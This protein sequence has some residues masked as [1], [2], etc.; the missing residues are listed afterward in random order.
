MNYTPEMLQVM[1]TQTEHVIEESRQAQVAATQAALV[2]LCLDA[3]VQFP[4]TRWLH[5]EDSDQGNYKYL[6]NLLDIHMKPVDPNANFC[7]EYFEDDGLTSYLDDGWG[8]PVW[9]P[10]VDHDGYLDVDAVLV[11][12]QDM[13]LAPPETV[14]IVDGKVVFTPTPHQR[15]STDQ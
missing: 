2:T 3:K 8:S 14:Q 11:K 5:V 10:F 6:L 15:R 13:F 1:N 12:Y 4:N 9:E 7:D